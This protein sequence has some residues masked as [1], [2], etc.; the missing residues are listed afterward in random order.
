[1]EQRQMPASQLMSA[2]MHALFDEF[3]RRIGA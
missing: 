3:A 2:E 1:M